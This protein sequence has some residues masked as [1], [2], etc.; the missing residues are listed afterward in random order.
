[1]K[2]ATK[3]TAG[4]GVL[5]A[6]MTAALIY[7]VS[8]IYQAQSVNRNLSQIN[9][10]AVKL[11]LQLIKEIDQTEEFTHKFVI[12]SDP[13]YQG[14]SAEA[15]GRFLELLGRLNSLSL[16]DNERLHVHHLSQTWDEV[17]LLVSG[18][19]PAPRESTKEEVDALMSGLRERFGQMVSQAEALNLASRQAIDAEVQRSAESGRR[20]ELISGVAAAGAALLSVLVSL[21]VVRSISVRLRQLTAGT[22]ALTEG[23]FHYQLDVSP[24]D[25]FAQLAR[26][27]NT[28]TNRLE[29]LDQLK[30]DFVSYV[31]HDLK[32]PL[33]SMQETT[34]LL[35]D[36]I[37]GPLTE[38]QERL[39]DLNLQSGRR[40]SAMINKLLDISRMEA[41]IIAYEFKDQDLNALIEPLLREFENRAEESGRTLVV[42]LSAEPLTVACDGDRILQVIGNLLE[43]ALKFSPR[44]TSVELFLGQPDRLRGPSPRMLGRRLPD[45]GREE[46]R[47]ALV[48]VADSGPG[49]PDAHKEKI[50]QKFHQVKQGKKVSGQGVGLG[51]AI[52]RTIVDA[53]GG[54]IWVENN[55]N[56]GSLFFVLLPQSAAV[57]QREDRAFS[58][59][60]GVPLK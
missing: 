33:A 31:S 40:L 57:T 48:A 10:E 18:T 38:K 32:A 5:I 2:I 47:W 59:V 46:K 42:H 9:F 50:F 21:F 26:D 4:Y 19:S 43:N 53:H 52:C 17:S 41:G 1:M 8:L 37:P 55:S 34:S 22:R 51:L 3:I 13:D 45:T 44:G 58:S 7:Q 54:A 39:L 56:G 12:T 30:K 36:R 24:D 60:R 49:V 6:L 15:G 27:F 20:A 23:K 35:L 14:K 29:E 28:M 16:S 11:S 25:E